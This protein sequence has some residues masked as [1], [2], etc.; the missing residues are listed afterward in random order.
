MHAGL[1]L[2]DQLNQSVLS[3]YNTLD[4]VT[5]NGLEA[6]RIPTWDTN[7]QEERKCVQSVSTSLEL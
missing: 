4:T 7:L 1:G 5:G 6:S 3:L 2:K